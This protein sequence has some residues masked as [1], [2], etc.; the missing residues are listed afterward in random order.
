MVIPTGGFPRAK[1]KD[2]AQHP[3]NTNVNMENV[4]PR[5][6]PR[7]NQV[8]AD[9]ALDAAEGRIGGQ[10]VVVDEPDFGPGFG[11]G[12]RVTEEYMK[13]RIAAVQVFVLPQSTVTVCNIV[14]DNGYSVRGESACVSEANFNQ[15]IGSDLAYKDA[16]RKLWALFGFALAEDIF[17]GRNHQGL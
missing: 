7:E 1:G 13:K 2:L 6:N 8:G 5:G 3:M 14:L 17:H 12:P 16:F 10:I 4:T 11:P 9:P 15:Q